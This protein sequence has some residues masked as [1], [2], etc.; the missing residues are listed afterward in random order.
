MAAKKIKVIGAVAAVL[1]VGAG[2]GWY[3][4]TG[5]IVK[6]TSQWLEGVASK[7]LEN[8]ATYT[9]TYDSITRSSFPAIG[10][11]LVNPTY[12]F[13]AP[14]DDNEKQPPVKFSMKLN[15]TADTVTDY[16]GNAYRFTSR[17]VST[18]S[19]DFGEEHLVA[20]SEPK[21]WQASIK[22][23]DR[24]T[25]NR[26]STL[27]FNDPTAVQAAVKGLSQVS[28]DAGAVTYKD[29]TGAVLLS[30]EKT[31]LRFTNRS[32]DT[33]IDFDLAFEVKAM[34]AGEAYIQTVE[35]LVGSIN[36]AMPMK[37]SDMPFSVARAGKQDMDVAVS[38]NLP[39]GFG[40]GPAGTGSI[41]VSK[42]ALK[43]NYYTLTAPTDIALS[44][45]N[46]QRD[47]K[48]KLDW[49][50]DVSPTGGLEG[51]RLVDM[52][53]S[54]APQPSADSPLDPELLKQKI[55]AALPTVST[56]GPISL[57]VDMDATAPK[58]TANADANA[59]KGRDSVTLRQFRFG[60]KRWALEAK[61]ESLN[62]EKTG[63]N[64]NVNLTCKQCDT[65][66]GDLFATAQGVQEVMNLST[67]NRPQWQLT[68]ELLTQLN[69]TLAEIGSKDASG[70]VSFAFTSPKPGDVAVNGKPVAEAL[71][72]LMMLF[73]AVQPPAV[74]VAE[75]PAPLPPSR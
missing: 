57:V 65:L 54:M 68:P 12:T 25:F 27:D 74:P 39:Q 69:S 13:E 18:I 35:R 14:G 24:Q 37:L 50:L 59:P 20:T 43:N 42:L 2:G 21:T 15:G 66:T 29:A 40:A 72:K 31:G 58:P 26:W 51:Q 28:F 45:A 3:V 73:A 55:T 71:P 64:I 47:V 23:K 38:V 36:P 63:A 30:S 9:V 46:G 16:L 44:E 22:A 8:G 49:S 11:R 34:E 70:D 7:K 60:H 6:N 61:G 48:I 75:Q 1:L 33:S 41:R 5:T 10:V 67:P 19:V 52:I 56:L 32:A 4:V 17:G 62:D 53:A